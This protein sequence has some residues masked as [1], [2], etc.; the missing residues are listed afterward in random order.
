MIYSATLKG[1]HLLL[2]LMLATTQLGELRWDTA[3]ERLPRLEGALGAAVRLGQP[4]AEGWLLLNLGRAIF[5]LGDIHH[6]ITTWERALSLFQARGDHSREGSTLG[7]L[8]TAYIRLGE[9]QRAIA[10]YE[11]ALGIF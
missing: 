3:H 5:D 10:V 9:I 1:D 8:A 7:N 6:A 2:D 11:Q 4:D